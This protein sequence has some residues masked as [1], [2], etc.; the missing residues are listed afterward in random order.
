MGPTEGDGTT[1]DAFISKLTAA[2]SALAYSTY[3]GGGGIDVANAVAVDSSGA[4]YVAGYTDSTDF[5]TMGPIEGDG[6]DAA[7][8]AF[9]SKLNAAGSALAYSTYLGGN[10]GD[11]ARAIAVDASGGAYVA[12]EAASTDFNTVGPIEGDGDGSTNDAFISKIAVPAPT[13]TDTDPDSP[14]N[15]NTVL[16]KGAAA[17]ATSVRLY[18]N[19]SCTGAPL[20]A[21]PATQFASPGLAV[22]VPDNSTTALHAT[23]TDAASVVSACSAAFTYTEDSAQPNSTISRVRVNSRRRKAT[24]T[25]SGTDTASSPSELDFECKLD[26]RSFAPCGSPKTYSR[27]KIGRHTVKVRATDEAGNLEASV[28]SRRFQV[29]RR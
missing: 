19:A 9:I 16:V 18:V 7:S 15:D 29:G 22:T 28:A 21:A 8:D 24:V 13:I 2:G 20:A 27:L 26:R 11:F 1:T 4:A 3:L 17:A 14:A 6:G 10:S 12:G 23:D 5:D 25:F